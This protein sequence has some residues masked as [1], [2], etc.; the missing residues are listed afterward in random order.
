VGTGLSDRDQRE[1]LQ[2]LKPIERKKC[3]FPV[4]PSISG[5]SRRKKLDLVT[6][7]KPVFVASV[8]YL[9]KTPAGE[10]RHQSFIRLRTDKNPEEVIIE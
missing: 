4:I 6:W 2:K 7:C 9:E 1:I 8:K 10:L 5:K 3:V